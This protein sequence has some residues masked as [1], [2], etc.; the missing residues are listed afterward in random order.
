MKS[1]SNL[2]WFFLILVIGIFSILPLLKTGFFSIHDDMHVAWLYEMDR[3]V[4]GGQIPPRWAPDLSY[5]YGYPLFNF[6]YPLPFYLGEIFYSLGFNLVSSIKIVFALSLLLSGPAMFLFLKRHFSSFFSFIGAVVYVFT[7]YRA[8]DVYVRGAIG[9]ALSFVLIPFIAWAENKTVKE[10]NSG[11]IAVLSICFGLLVLTHNISLI[12]VTPF[13][14]VYGLIIVLSLKG[15]AQ[16]LKKLFL[17]FFL[18]GTLSSFFWLPALLE[19]KYMVSDTVFN[20]IDHFPFIKQLIVPFWGYGSSVWGPGDWMSFQIGIA[21]LLIFVIASIILIMVLIRKKFSKEIFPKEILLLIWTIGGFILAIFMMNIRSSFIWQTVPL[22]QYFQFPWRFLIL[23][24][25]FTSIMVG[26]IELLPLRDKLKKIIAVGIGLL[27]IVLTFSYFRPDKIVLER[28]DEYYMNRYFANK[29][30]TGY[31]G[32]ISSIYQTTKEE[33]LRLPVWTK[34]RPDNVPLEKIQVEEGDLSF[35][36]ISSTNYSAIL[37]TK[38]TTKVFLNSYFFPGWKAYIDG[39]E[40][41]IDPGDLYGNISI[42][43]PAGTHNLSF[44][45]KNTFVHSAANVISLFSWILVLFLLFKRR[46]QL[47]EK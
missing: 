27:S 46:K 29:T 30:K 18:G 22:M 34:E 3:A 16:A 6:V 40:T 37:S 7:P 32:S 36:E 23:T 21:N 35:K 8:V 19:K 13:L 1:K 25:F 4:K 31:T 42:E 26:F 24:T 11:S 39:K 41:K 28:T 45:F 47:G 2:I 38:E 10:E 44:V 5:N 33:Y 14:L 12:M 43:V 17:G 9:E 15:K 20:Y